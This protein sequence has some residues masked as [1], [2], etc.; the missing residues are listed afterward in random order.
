MVKKKYT[1]W[2][3]H[4]GYEVKGTSNPNAPHHKDYSFTMTGLDDLVISESHPISKLG[5][6]K[7][8]IGGEFLVIRNIVN[9]DHFLDDKRTYKGGSSI[10]S[11]TLYYW[12]PHFAKGDIGVND[13]PLAEI[14]DTSEMDLIGTKAIAVTIPTNPISDLANT[15]GEI[16]AE[17]IPSVPIINSWKNRT[18]HARNAGSEYLNYQ[19][20]WLPLVRELQAFSHAVSNSEELIRQYDRQSGTDIKRH[21]ALPKEIDVV[22]HVEQVGGGFTHITPEPFLDV[23]YYNGSNGTTK[24]TVTRTIERQSWFDGCFTYYIPP[25]NPNGSNFRRNVQ[26]AQKL[27]GL[28]VTPETIWNLAPWTWALDWHGNIGDVLHNLSAF[29]Q[30]GLVMRYGYVMQTTIHKEE[31]TLSNVEFKSFPGQKVN[32]STSIST[33]VKRRRKATPYGFGLDWDG[34]TAHQLAILGALGL[35]RS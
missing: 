12:G 26:L 18:R 22:S 2:R 32:L 31:R 28:E 25:F 4:T 11:G 33:V 24:R 34:F 19:F 29:R 1:K 23:R 7:Q 27:F 6:T 5:K 13:W 20:G 8:D 17:G 16:R 21:F 15:L 9:H 35:S 3:T 10:P 14:P 30:D